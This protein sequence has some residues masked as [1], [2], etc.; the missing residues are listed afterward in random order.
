MFWTERA[1]KATVL[2][3]DF[4]EIWL[5]L[6]R[7]IRKQ[8]SP[9]ARHIADI[10]PIATAPPALVSDKFRNFHHFALVY[11][12]CSTP[13]NPSHSCST[14]SSRPRSGNWYIDSEHRPSG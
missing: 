12:H 6:P 1:V 3:Q 9:A 10:G 2:R 4:K 13:A 8:V 5:Y 14:P 7:P 11:F